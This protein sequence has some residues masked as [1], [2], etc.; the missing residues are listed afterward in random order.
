MIDLREQAI[1]QI[2]GQNKRPRG[3]ITIAA[4]SIPHQYVLPK[5]MV[6]FCDVYPEISFNILSHDSAG[7][8]ECI[9]YNSAQIGLAGTSLSDFQCSYDPFHDYELVIVLPHYETY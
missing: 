9:F 6:E 4:S 7:V 3:V 1:R 8:A 5:L 2:S